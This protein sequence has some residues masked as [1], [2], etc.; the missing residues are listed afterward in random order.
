VNA[1]GLWPARY[2]A[3]DRIHGLGG[4]L[5]WLGLTLVFLPLAVHVGF[6]LKM[7]RGAGFAY[8]TGKHHRGGDLRF[9]LQ[10]V[11]ALIL[12]AFLGLHILTLHDWGFHQIYR[13]TSWAALS[14]Y[15]ASGLFHP[16]QAY[17]S[18]T[19]A[20]RDLASPAGLRSAGNVIVMGFY[21]LAIWATAY[22]LSN[23]LSTTAMV[24]NLL[25]KSGPELAAWRD[26]PPRPP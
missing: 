15:Q 10:R 11:S 24:W 21:L 5:P 8:H 2:Q 7:L 6:G 23:G 1:L 19:S 16:D 3:V 26:N 25:R 13:L 20:I 18:A 4:L 12:L 17:T 14:P 22:H 9:L